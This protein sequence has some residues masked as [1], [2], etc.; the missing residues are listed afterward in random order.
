MTLLSVRDLSLAT[1]G[2]PIL[3][4]ASFDIREGEVFGLLG[5]SGSGQ[6][7]IVRRKRPTGRRSRWVPRIELI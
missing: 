3:Q 5:V 6:W 7:S 1:H 4:G 2:A